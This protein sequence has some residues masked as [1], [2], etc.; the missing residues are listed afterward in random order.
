M[1]TS[2]GIAM[3]RAMYDRYRNSGHGIEYSASMALR[4]SL[5]IDPTMDYPNSW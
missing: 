3:Y 5:R 2:A 1:P 4:A